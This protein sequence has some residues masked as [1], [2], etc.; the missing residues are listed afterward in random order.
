ML[1]PVLNEVGT[2]LK[3]Q[4]TVAKIDT[5]KYPAL[6]SRFRIEGL[7][8]CVLFK[9]SSS[10]IMIPDIIRDVICFVIQP[11]LTRHSVLL[12]NLLSHRVTAS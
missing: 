6:A 12:Y 3:G 5:D 2:N 11:A 4:V 10:C 1:A 7:P 9:V 8:T